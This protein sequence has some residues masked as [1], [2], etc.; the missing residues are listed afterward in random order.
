M[1]KLSTEAKAIRLNK[2]M[3]LALK[4]KIEILKPNTTYEE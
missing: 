4:G 3:K 2:I 1:V